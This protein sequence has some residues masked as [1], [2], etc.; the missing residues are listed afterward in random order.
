MID[1]LNLTIYRQPDINFLELQGTITEAERN[2]IYKYMCV[3]DKCVVLYR[4]HKFSDEVNF[5]IRYTKIDINPKH[6]ECWLDCL[7]YL[8][9]IFNSTDLSLDTFNI[10]RIDIAADI[11][12]LS[13]KSI[14]A[15]LNI[16]RIRE[17]NFNFYRGTIYGGTDPKIR[18]YDKIKEIKARLKKKN[19]LTQY[20]KELLETGKSWIRFEI[21][22]RNT[23]MTL[24]NLVND[25]ASLS[26]Y[27]DRLEFFKLDGNESHTVMHFVY[28]LINR[29][30]RKEIDFIKNNDLVEKI[31]RV[32]REEVSKWFQDREPF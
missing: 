19:D 29:K 27:F 22:I 15:T 13:M 5:R 1:K 11:E 10:S 21:Q 14:L 23:K 28:R 3:L 16:K 9:Q 7:Q 17:D 18:I 25:P 31:K 12:D 2:R 24:Q 4:P 8:Y 6:F 20:E 32:Y 26:F 30:H